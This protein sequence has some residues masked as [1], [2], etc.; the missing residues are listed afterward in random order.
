[1]STLSKSE[2][3]APRRLLERWPMASLR[4]E[5]DDLFESFFGEGALSS[6]ARGR[7]VPQ[8]DV[9][10]TDDTV[11]VKT[12]LPGIQADEVEIEIRENYLT[13]S[14]QHREEHESDEGNG[15]KFHRVERRSGSFSRSVWLPCAVNEDKVDAE[16]KD[17]VLTVTMPKI[18]KAK[19][20]K[21]QVKA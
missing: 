13:I 11:E 6:T 3:P 20:R 12:D 16:L 1:M 9:S 4:E 14:G 15:R 18:E 10:E 8:M 19:A 17:G 2:K 7:L 21:I 5:M